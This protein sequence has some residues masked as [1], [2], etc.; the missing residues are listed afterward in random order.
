MSLDKVPRARLQV[1]T[2][3]GDGNASLSV[4]TLRFQPTLIVIYPQLAGGTYMGW[5]VAAD[6]AKTFVERSG[7]NNNL[8]EDD[9][10]ISIDANGFTVGDGTGGAGNFF[11]VLGRVYVALC[12]LGET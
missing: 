1:V 11:N 2:Y 7:S 5:K 4:A 3:T 10:I 9:H 6:G 8:Y 12:H